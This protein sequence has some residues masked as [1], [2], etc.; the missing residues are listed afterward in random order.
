VAVASRAVCLVTDL[1]ASGVCALAMASRL[2][3]PETIT[4]GATGLPR[5]G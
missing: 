3:R 2:W 4:N 5:S 1:L